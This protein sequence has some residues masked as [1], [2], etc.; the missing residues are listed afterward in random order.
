MWVERCLRNMLLALP[1]PPNVVFIDERSYGHTRSRAGHASQRAVAKVLD[2]NAY[3]F[4]STR[5]PEIVEP[6]P[7][8]GRVEL[9]PVLDTHAFVLPEAD[10]KL[11]HYYSD[12]AIDCPPFT[13]VPETAVRLE[14]LPTGIVA[15]CQ[16]HRRAK[17]NYPE[18]FELL[19]A[20]LA[21]HG[22]TPSE[23]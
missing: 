13:T 21:H 11:T 8:D 7:S 15:R 5:F 17:D 19:V 14:H 3:E 6:K 23:A 4:L 18:A 20:L 22:R 2:E 16:L 1:Q 12:A 10:L 9:V